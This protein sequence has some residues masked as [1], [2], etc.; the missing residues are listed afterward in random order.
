MDIIV[1][2][3]GGSSVKDKESLEHV[4]S[5]IKAEKEKKNK[6]VVVVSAQGKTTD[7][8]IAKAKEYTNNTYNKE[9]DL[10]LSTGEIITVSL[11]TMMLKDIG[12]EAIGLTGSQA[13]I[14]TDSNYSFAKIKTVFRENILKHLE[15]NDVVVVAGFQGVDKFGNITTLGRGGSDLS[16]VAIAAALNAKRC[17][18]YTDVDGVY[19][20]D[21]NLIDNAKLLDAVSYDEMLEAASSGAKVLHNRAVSMAKK[22]KLKLLVKNT[23]NDSRGTEVIEEIGVNEKKI[24]RILAVEKDL[25]RITLVGEELMSNLSNIQTLYNIAAEE[26]ISL[27]LVSLSETKLSIVVKN[28]ECERILNKIH[29]RMLEN[30]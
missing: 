12:Y 18:I 27:K 7:G 10:L 19:N 24:P 20:T 9:L 28:D 2:K 17:E 30:V 21:P 22:Y 25:V 8:L 16:A 1:Q 13:G 6:V 3:F 29:K 5:K 15:N 14:I 23:K 11:L 26:N 4:I